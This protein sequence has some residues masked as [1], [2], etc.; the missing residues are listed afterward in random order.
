M[1]T[2]TEILGGAQTL[3]PLTY[4]LKECFLE[5]L[6]NDQKLFLAILQKIE[7]VIEINERQ[8]TMGLSA[9]PQ[10]AFF[11][12][13][14]A[15]S[16]FKLDTLKDLRS[17]LKVDAN[18]RLLCGFKNVP[19]PPTFS[20]RHSSLAEEKLSEIAHE[21]LIRG[22][23]SDILVGHI[24]RDSTAIAVRSKVVKHSEYINLNN[25]KKYKRETP[26]R[27]SPTS[28]TNRRGVLG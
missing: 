17:R 16:F 1:K 6:T 24:S 5:Y 11:R 15:Q 13:F 23:L 14:L 3:L 12:A 7:S 8:T 28:S 27:I 25:T 26:P 22:H 19:S 20:R 21:N 4:E 18:L 10:K 2:I 9:Y